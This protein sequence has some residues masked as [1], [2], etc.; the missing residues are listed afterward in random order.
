MCVCVCE[1]YYNY[2]FFVMLGVFLEGGGLFVFYSFL[3]VCFVLFY[4]FFFT[5][6]YLYFKCADNVYCLTPHFTVLYDKETILIWKVAYRLKR[7]HPICI[8]ALNSGSL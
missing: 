6:I 2:Y 1:N 4:I 7:C 3:F 8:V 5:F